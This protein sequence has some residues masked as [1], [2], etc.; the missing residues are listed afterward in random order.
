MNK[1]LFPFKSF[2][3]GSYIDPKICDALIEEHKKS[4]DVKDGIINR[5]HVNIKIK[6]S[7]DL[8]CSPRPEGSPF[9]DYLDALQ[10]VVNEYEEK[11]DE[12]K[13][14]SSYSIVQNWNVQWYRPGGGYKVWHNERNGPGVG[15][16]RILVFMTYLN[17]VPDGGTEFKYLD[18]IAPAK[19]GLTLI[20]P[21]DSTHTHRSQRTRKHEKYIAT[22]WFHYQWTDDI[23]AEEF[24]YRGK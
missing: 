14:L 17:D 22:G 16:H 11:Y 2:I 19:K 21:T 3:H 9:T 20:W 24:F 10:K 8:T 15:S 13:S 23:I 5:G 4:P 18:I 1:E 6:E 12:V 7:K